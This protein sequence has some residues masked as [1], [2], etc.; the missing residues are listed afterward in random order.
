ML[1]ERL[2]RE[3][4]PSRNSLGVP[5][6]RTWFYSSQWIFTRKKMLLCFGF[7]SLEVEFRCNARI[8]IL[9]SLA[10]WAISSGEAAVVGS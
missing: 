5:G 10:F 7:F 2:Q 6:K 8:W 1:N 9:T 4:L 3:S